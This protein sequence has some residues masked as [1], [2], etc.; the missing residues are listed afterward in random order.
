MR[1]VARAAVVRASQTPPAP[2]RNSISERVGTDMS[3]VKGRVS[4]G[5]R[6]VSYTVRAPHRVL[7]YA[8]LLKQAHET[9]VRTTP[10]DNDRLRAV[11]KQSDA[12]IDEYLD[13]E[14]RAILEKLNQKFH[15]E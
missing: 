5:M 8:Q 1:R 11:L 14:C 6:I 12:D 13:A 9:H 4:D 3:V 10:V 15:D 7:S 2:P